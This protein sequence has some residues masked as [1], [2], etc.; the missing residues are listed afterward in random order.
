M[1]NS[2]K[3]PPPFMSKDNMQVIIGIFTRYMS[4]TQNLVFQSSDLMDL[5]HT[6]FEIMNKTQE[7]CKKKPRNLH[8]MNLEVLAATKDHYLQKTNKTKPNVKKLDREKEVFGNRQVAIN[9]LIPQRDPYMRKPISDLDKFINEREDIFHKQSP[10]ISRLGQQSVDPP[11]NTDDFLRKLKDLEDNRSH[12]DSIIQ[13]FRVNNTIENQDPKKM[14]SMHDNEVFKSEP[15]ELG[16]NGEGVWLGKETHGKDRQDGGDKDEF[17]TSANLLI[18]NPTANTPASMVTVQK[19][20][21][22]NSFDR[23]WI[24]NSQRYTYSVGFNGKDITGNFKNI[25]CIQVGKV[26]IPEEINENINILNYPNKTQFNHEFSFSFPYLVLRIDEF[27]DVY[28]GTNDTIRKGF[29]KL[30][31]HRHYKAPNGRGYVILKPFQKEKKIFLPNPLGTLSRLSISILKPN[32]FLLNTSSDSYKIWKIYYD[33]FN[34]HYYTIVTDVFFDKNEFYVG[35]VVQFKGFTI[36]NTSFS[37][38]EDVLREFINRPEGHEIVQIGSTNNNGYY[39]SFYIG[40]IG[41][42]NRIE[43][44]F[45]TNMDAVSCLNEYNDGIDY[46]TYTG[47]NGY[48]LNSSLQNTIGLSIDVLVSGTP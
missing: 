20:I 4:D 38:Q 16:G 7:S 48:I 31:Y 35:D 3:N 40:A 25:R 11:E 1:N 47:T 37:I 41:T 5:K 28:D 46:N 29:C 12:V 43:G 36:S 8:Q 17:N 24:M 23:D 18:P 33:P 19:F 42:F 30:V 34:P 45:D 15:H 26:V 9:E 13:E 32:G 22:I 2:T 39:R 10:D 14:Y 27:N 44:K 21:S 6:V